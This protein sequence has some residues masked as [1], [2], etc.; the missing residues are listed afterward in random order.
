MDIFH[1]HGKRDIYHVSRNSIII[2][3][4]I[5]QKRNIIAS[6]AIELKDKIEL[7][8]TESTNNET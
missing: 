8:T 5:K 2:W 3:I 7:T 1:Q 6:I 4:N